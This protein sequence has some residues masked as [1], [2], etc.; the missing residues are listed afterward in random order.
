[1]ETV[2]YLWSNEQRQLDEEN[3]LQS[4]IY[5][6]EINEVESEQDNYEYQRLFPSFDSDFH[7]FLPSNNNNPNKELNLNNSKSSTLPYYLL[8]EYFSSIINHE[9]HSFQN[10]LQPFFNSLYEFGEDNRLLTH[11]IRLLLKT[12]QNLSNYFLNIN[13]PF[14]IYQDSKSSMI[15][16]CYSTIN[17]IEQRTNDLLIQYENH[18]TL[19]EILRIIQRIQTFSI[20]NSLIKFL[21][22]FDLLFDKLTYWQQT[23]ASKTLQTTFNNELDLLISH[24]IEYRQYEFNCYEQTLSMI[25]YNQRQLIIE[26]WW[27]YLF[28]IMN[29][30]I[31]DFI[32]LE[33]NLHEF[34]QQSTL[35]D[36]QIRL[37]I[38]EILSNYFLHNETNNF[39]L[40]S[41]IKYYQQFQELIEKQKLNFIRKP[42][43]NEIKKFLNIQRWKDRN[44]YSLKQ[45]INKS[46]QFLFKSIKKYK[47]LILQP[48]GKF[49]SLYSINFQQSILTKNDDF[50]R[51]I[52]LKF[53]KTK[54]NLINYPLINEIKIDTNLIHQ[55]S[56][57]IHSMKIQDKNRKESKQIYTE[58]R[59]LITQLFKKLTS[60]GLSFRK[61]LLNIN[62]NN[63]NF[64]SISIIKFNFY[65]LELNNQNYALINTKRNKLIIINRLNILEKFSLFFQQIDFNYYKI[66]YQHNQLCLFK[67]IHKIDPIIYQRIHGFLRHLFEIIFQQ[68]FLL[69]QLIQQYVNFSKLFS[70][71]S[72]QNFQYSFNNNEIDQLYHLTISL[73]ERTYSFLFIIQTIPSTMSMDNIPI[74]DQLPN[75]IDL[76]KL[77]DLKILLEKFLEHLNLLIEKL[78]QYYD[79]IIDYHPLVKDIYSLHVEICSIKEQIRNIINK[80]FINENSFPN[81]QFL[82]Q[83]AK[84]FLEIYE[85]FCQ[86]NI[87][88]ENKGVLY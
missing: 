28:D 61:G 17:L 5:R 21:Y 58:K 4:S 79:C 11:M 15:I 14:D 29:S 67:Q 43:E 42:I 65:S 88:E 77:N 16:Q 20:E 1:M 74:L 6:H 82:G 84:N 55:L 50:F 69:H 70:I 56:S 51:L 80:M 39:I 52:H 62:F 31:D 48:I 13:K 49:L 63:K 81:E 32:S 66:I 86:I 44:Y 7:D 83:L 71:Y 24:I 59:Q 25:D 19:N 54:F 9:K 27:L 22:G 75:Y 46:H 68:K 60:I 85:Q 35:G 18:P 2:H 87:L 26:Q 64:H 8:F 30:K 57:T 37:E 38:C 34:F 40:H 10:L 36:F 33:N 3:R 72:K 12:K 47:Q 76:F 23:Y 53:N 41:L 45:S 78:N 73:I